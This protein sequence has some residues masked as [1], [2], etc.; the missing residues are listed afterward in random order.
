M[1]VHSAC[2]W[3][4]LARDNDG[5]GT[6]LTSYAPLCHAPPWRHRSCVSESLSGAI[7]G[8][9]LGHTPRTSTN[10]QCSISRCT[11]VELLKAVVDNNRKNV[12]KLEQYNGLQSSAFV[13]QSE[14][15]PDYHF[16]IWTLSHRALFAECIWI[17]RVSGEIQSLARVSD[18]MTPGLGSQTELEIG[19][20]PAPVDCVGGLA[21]IAGAHSVTTVAAWLANSQHLPIVSLSI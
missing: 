18:V 21:E 2:H 19:N 20:S 9:N 14:I 10:G 4:V 11:F 15:E 8:D 3:I 1:M 5:L 6:I 7:F 17:W 13:S 12:K 16:Q